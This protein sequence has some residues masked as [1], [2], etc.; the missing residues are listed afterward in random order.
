MQDVRE[1]RTVKQLRDFLNT[2]LENTS[3]GDLD[4]I[5]WNDSGEDTFFPAVLNE[6]HF[7]LC[8]NPSVGDSFDPDGNLGSTVLVEYI[9]HDFRLDMFPTESHLEDE[10]S[11]FSYTGEGYPSN[12]GN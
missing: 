1:F 5:Q 9:N 12:F 10:T 7:K 4:L 11:I 6:N 8:K 3:D 2:L